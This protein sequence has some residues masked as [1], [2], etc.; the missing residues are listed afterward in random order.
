MPFTVDDLDK[1]VLGML[2]RREQIRQGG[3]PLMS[4]LD[5]LRQAKMK[6]PKIPKPPRAL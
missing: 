3:V 6:V 1:Q 5:K 4:M 2:G